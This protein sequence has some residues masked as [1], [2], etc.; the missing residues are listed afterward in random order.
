M[1]TDLIII[2]NY[3]VFLL[4]VSFLITTFIFITIF[5]KR[6]YCYGIS[7]IPNNKLWGFDL[8]MLMNSDTTSSENNYIVS[9]IENYGKI[10]QFYY[11]N[12]HIVLINDAKIAN[13]VL[14]KVK[15]K[16]Y[17]YVSCTINDLLYHF[18]N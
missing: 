3:Q 13:L 10:C 14:D 7:T 2:D 11:L 15:G 8:L 4:L 1:T 5:R 16:E 6:H 9:M 12:K 17:Y 18:Y